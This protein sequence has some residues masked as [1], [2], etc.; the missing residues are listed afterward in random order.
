M[1]HARRDRH[2]ACPCRG[3]RVMLSISNAARTAGVNRSTI[4]RAIKSGRLSVTLDAA[5]RRGID[6][7]ELLRAFG[8]LAP[9]TALQQAESAAM[10]QSAA[11]VA[12]PAG[13]HEVAAKVPESTLLLQLLHAQLEQAQ[14]REIRLLAILD[15][16]LVARRSLEQRLLPAPRRS[17]W[18]PFGRSG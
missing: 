12:V 2:A 18:W 5:G 15:Q 14:A 4:Q 6:M 13:D 16:E 11:S 7:A 1:Q 3:K 9:A 8:P 10:P 17:W